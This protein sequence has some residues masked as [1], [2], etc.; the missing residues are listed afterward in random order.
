M[1]KEEFIKLVEKKPYILGQGSGLL[2]QRYKI[3]RESVLEVKRKYNSNNSNKRIEQELKNTRI[4]ILD[5]ETSPMK[6]YVWS[7]W[8]ENVYLEQTISEWF[9]LAW[10]AKWLYSGEIMGEIL[11]SE[12][13]ANEDDKRIMTKLHTLLNQA[14]IVVA[15]NGVK[16][17]LP[18]INSRFIING[19]TPTT[20]YFI[21]DTYLIAKKQFGFS[22]NKLDALA[23]YFNIPHK[24]E[25][26]FNLWRNCMEGNEKALKY[27]LE[28]NKRDVAIL[29][30]VYLRLRPWIKN[31][32]NIG[33][34]ENLECACA[35]CGSTDY[36][37]LVGEYYFTN[38]GKY[39]LYRCKK[40]DAIFRSRKSEKF[41]IK[42]TNIS[43]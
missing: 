28:Y 6:A 27:M 37:V 12:E 2:S 32:P 9:C 29:E 7:R 5:I 38:V 10:S 34:L 11:T 3:S 20:P 22:S 14:D 4:L 8:H 30:E 43:R 17:D 19:L 26:D 24:L 15:H 39:Q 1:N 16:F 31:H 13:V 21:I 40:C 41:K 25:T 35:N 36:E 18:K 42:T 23:S 33:N